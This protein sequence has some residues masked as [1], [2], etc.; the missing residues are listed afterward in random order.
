VKNA[1]KH[2]GR[3]AAGMLPAALLVRLG[4]PAL[5]SLVFLATLGIGVTCW[6]I[7]DPARSDRVSRMMLASRGDA[8]CLEP[9]TSSPPSPASQASPSGR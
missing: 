8:R 1:L 6:I 3:A 4:L 2:A 7:S 9:G 5:A